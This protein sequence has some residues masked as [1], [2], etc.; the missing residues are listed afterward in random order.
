[1]LAE[2]A[3]AETAAATRIGGAERG[4]GIW[5]RAATVGS[6]AAGT[7]CVPASLA[8]VVECDLKFLG[9]GFLPRGSSL[10]TGDSAVV[11]EGL[12]VPLRGVQEEEESRCEGC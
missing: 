11:P 3:L 6:S 12:K 7:P 2:S 5:S 1:M 10:D 4:V 9:A 8:K